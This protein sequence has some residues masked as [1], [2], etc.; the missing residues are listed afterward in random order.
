MTVVSAANA[1]DAVR[2]LAQAGPFD[3]AL[4]DQQHPEIEGLALAADIRKQPY[5]RRLPI[6]LL[7]SVPM[8]G[9]AAGGNPP[10]IAGIVHKPFKPAQ[11]LDVLCRALS[12]QVQRERKA[13]AIPAL[14][15]HLARRLPLRLLLADDNPINQKVGLSVL[16]KLG[17][18]ADV[19]NNGKE[20]LKALEQ[21]RYDL[22]FLDVQM[23]EMD[24]LEA[25]RQIRLRWSA[26]KRPCIVAMT[27]NALAGDRE[28]CLE[29][30]MDDYITK[31]M[32][33]GELQAAIERWGPTKSSGG[34]DTAFLAAPRSATTAENVLDAAVI[35]DLRAMPPSNGI[36]M[37]QELIDLF[38]EDAP[39][40]LQDISNSLLDGPQLTFH[41]HALRSMCLSLGAK[42]LIELC[43]QLEEA[44]RNGQHPEAA[45]L[46][47]NL[48]RAFSQTRDQLLRLRDR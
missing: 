20:V 27:G 41:A 11:L 8:S 12:V 19:V 31:P 23:P 39:K 43:Q 48:Q 4:L 35:A 1:D 46:N 22:L 38:L 10:G 15:H 24:G 32:R 44:G 14:D 3:V 30:G 18:R 17:Y 29:A 9:E 45:V 28:K 42:R 33:I 21:R 2:Q 6:I 5:S 16:Q 37:L 34:G 26:E 13:P 25:A 40:R 36:S 47:Q 7:S